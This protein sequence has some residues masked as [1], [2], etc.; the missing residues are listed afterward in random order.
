[1][2][3]YSILALAV[4]LVTLVGSAPTPLASAQS[5]LTA[6]LDGVTAGYGS[7]AWKDVPPTGALPL[8]GAVP[9]S[10]VYENPYANRPHYAP[11]GPNYMGYWVE[12]NVSIVDG[13]GNPAAAPTNS[14]YVVSA[15]VRTAVGNIPARIERVDATHFSVRIDADGENARGD[16]P[17]LPSG[18]AILHVEVYEAPTDPTQT[19]Q[20]IGDAD[21]PFGSIAASHTLPGFFFPEANLGFYTEVGPGNHTL[22][23]PRQITAD[24]TIPVTFTFG[25]RNASAQVVLVSNRAQTEVAS[26]KTDALGRFRVNVT[27]ST[28]LGAASSGMLILEG[29]LRGGAP[30]ALVGNSV[31]LL[32]VSSNNVTFSEIKFE[33][34]GLGGLEADP[35]ANV[36]V[37]ALDASGTPT[38]SSRRGTL[39][40]QSGIEVL[41]TSEFMPD[42]TD[43]SLKTA[44][45]RAATITDDRL[46]Q[47][48]LFALF[49]DE[50]NRFYGM[51]GAER[52][53][54]VTGVAG[55]LKPFEEGVVNL[56]VRNVN[57]NM[58][59]VTDGGLSMPIRVLV[60]N[61]PGGGSFE[62]TVTIAEGGFA[63]VEVPFRADAA[64]FYAVDV[65]ATAGELSVARAVN[66]LVSVRASHD[67]TFWEEVI[68]GVEPALLIG[69]VLMFALLRRERRAR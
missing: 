17:P 24:A 54:S 18:P 66:V 34:R 21:L 29:H 32:P 35:L 55:R 19:R 67:M 33:G 16:V 63:F 69:A 27:P 50:Q 53:I 43:P 7:E 13:A 60:T 58:N 5:G 48:S 64:G 42:A 46:G 38:S 40:V 23:Y 25:V 45:F 26:G 8:P 36:R 62:R 57:D 20:K 68:P 52:G 49:S 37:T 28:A 41:A 59:G 2:R 1:M 51:A 14:R 6:A 10:G 44:R 11:V 56:T 47:Y 15:E 65:N 61:L 31:I 4:V 39:L 30:G 3:Q 9:S 22:V 12:F